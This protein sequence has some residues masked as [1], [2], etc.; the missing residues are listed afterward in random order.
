MLVAT[1][2]APVFF[3]SGP[4][5]AL[6]TDIVVGTLPPERAGSAASMSE[7]STELGISLGVALIESAGHAFIAELN[8][9]APTAAVT[10]WVAWPSWFV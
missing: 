3:G 8:H 7:T 4:V 5:S 9:A 6:G 2:I 10:G 1:D